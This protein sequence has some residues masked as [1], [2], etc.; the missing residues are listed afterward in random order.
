MGAGTWPKN[1]SRP[2][3]QRRRRKSLLQGAKRKKMLKKKKSPPKPSHFRIVIVAAAAV[4]QP[5][6][7]SKSGYVM[8]AT[9]RIGAF[10]TI[11]HSGLLLCYLKR[12][13]VVPRFK[14]L[15]SVPHFNITRTKS[16]EVID[17]EGKE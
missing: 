8:I 14:P 3:S 6:Q 9:P 11:R 7:I 10:L 17:V 16:V 12:S 15:L 5:Q 4:Q 1:Q 2:F 13:P